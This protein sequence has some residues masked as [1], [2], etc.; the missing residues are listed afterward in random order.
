MGVWH[1]AGFN[2]L[3]EQLVVRLGDRLPE[4]ARVELGWYLW[5]EE[6]L[7]ADTLAGVLVADQVPIDRRELDMVTEMLGYFDPSTTNATTYPRIHE[8]D[9]T[10]AALNVVD[11]P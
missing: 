4:D 6:G 7:M 10:L 8:R 1:F 11:E 3:A 5:E 2:E 9:A